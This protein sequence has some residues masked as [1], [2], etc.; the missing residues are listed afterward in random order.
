MAYPLYFIPKEN[1]SVFISHRYIFNLINT[2]L[3]ATTFQ[4]NMGIYVKTSTKPNL[5]I[6][7]RL[8]EWQH[9]SWDKNYLSLGYL[10]RFRPCLHTMLCQVLVANKPAVLVNEFNCYYTIV[11]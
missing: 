7:P 2:V 11:L 4:G 1:A 6:K 9:L 3:T 5:K 10:E 8:V